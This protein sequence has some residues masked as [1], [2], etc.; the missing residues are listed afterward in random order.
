MMDAPAAPV[1]PPLLDL[2]RLGKM[3]KRYAVD[4]EVE[5]L[6]HTA[7]A[8]LRDAGNTQL[9]IGTRYDLAYLSVRASSL[10]AL[11]WYNCHTDSTFLIFQSLQS[12]VGVSKPSWRI[13]NQARQQHDFLDTYGRVVPGERML[14]ALLDSASDVLQRVRTLT[15]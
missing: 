3:K 1:P 2:L 11:C 5:A 6:L 14:T 9:D 12:T 7:Q 4:G 10:V 15:Q 8:R 13:L